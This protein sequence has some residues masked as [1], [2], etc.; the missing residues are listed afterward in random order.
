VKPGFSEVETGFAVGVRLVDAR[1]RLEVPP[2]TRSYSE[3][4]TP[5]VSALTG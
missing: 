3:P 2:R 4:E 1:R 5:S